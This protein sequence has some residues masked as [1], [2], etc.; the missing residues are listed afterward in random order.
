MRGK[1]PKTD[2]EGINVPSCLGNSYPSC[3]T[4]MPSWLAFNFSPLMFRLQLR[5][6][7]YICNPSWHLEDIPHVCG[8]S[9]LPSCSTFMPS[10]LAL[11]F[12]PLM[13]RLRLEDIWSP[14]WTPDR[15]LK[16][17]VGA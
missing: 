1:K 2:H 17:R 13:V 10:W 11:Y 9:G 12:L 3:S 8:H 6:F 5:H 4:L 15:S 14:P 7:S 16:A